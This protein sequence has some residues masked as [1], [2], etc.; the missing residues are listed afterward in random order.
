[1]RFKSNNDIISLP[2]LNTG[3]DTL[4]DVKNYFIIILLIII[5]IFLPHLNLK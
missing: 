1:M 5:T 3:I 4:K 2:P